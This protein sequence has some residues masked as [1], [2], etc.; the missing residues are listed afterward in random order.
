VFVIFLKRK[1]EKRVLYVS[2]GLTSE[3]RFAV[4]VTAY[5]RYDY[6]HEAIR[7]DL[8]QSLKPTQVIVATDDVSRLKGIQGVTLVEANY[9]DLGKKISEA[10]K[11]VR[12]DVD[13]IALL[14]DDDLFD[15]DKLK[16]LSKI[17]SESQRDVV[18]VHNL[19]KVIDSHGREA[20]ENQAAYY[21]RGQPQTS[22]IVTRDNVIKVM[23]QYPLIHHNLSS[24][25]LRRGFLE[26][27]RDA[28][29]NLQFGIDFALF[30]LA[31][32]R[33]K[34]LHVPDRLTYYRIG[35]GHTTQFFN[36]LDKG[37]HEFVGYLEKRFCFEKKLVRSLRKLRTFI[38]NC[39]QCKALVE[40]QLL[41]SETLVL[42]LNGRFNCGLPEP[43]PVS[44][45][46]VLLLNFKSFF[47]RHIETGTF[48]K[49][50]F[51]LVGLHI[52]GK[53]RVSDMYIKYLYDLHY[54]AFNYTR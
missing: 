52:L 2:L 15:R 19:Q 34:V 3:V 53:R 7:Y 1:G 33:G 43:A 17:L 8:N 51:A 29:A 37:L 46:E 26:D 38:K 18:L 47:N 21:T 50:L 36:Y 30:H 9:P 14:D 54:K 24:M 20:K 22:L 27:V 32:E 10:A 41:F 42:L 45:H 25:T 5:R 23:R 12:D 44:S 4:I 13:A 48:L 31:L 35:S 11:F 16:V 40:R 39:K 6:V 49:T 28:L